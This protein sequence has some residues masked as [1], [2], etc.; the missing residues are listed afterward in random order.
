VFG[1]GGNRDR[2][3][4]SEMGAVATR[5]ADHV[6]LTDDNPRDEDGQDIVNDILSGCRQERVRV[7]RDRK[8][9]I[10]NAIYEAGANDWV[11]VAG[12]GHEDYQEIAGR[13]Y[14]FSDAETVQRTLEMRVNGEHAVE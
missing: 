12:K 3:K 2:G 9:A 1:C 10:E 11:V 7:V 4:R 6:I 13:R 8:Q 5:W 14:P